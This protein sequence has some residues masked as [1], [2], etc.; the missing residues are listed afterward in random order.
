M[1]FEGEVI[2]TFNK[3]IIEVSG[4]ALPP[5]ELIMMCVR[6]ITYVNTLVGEFS[7]Q[8]GWCVCVCVWCHIKIMVWGPDGLVHAQDITLIVGRSR[9]NV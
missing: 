8:L 7:H 3:N 2:E 4:I 1:D 5:D 9:R 6:D